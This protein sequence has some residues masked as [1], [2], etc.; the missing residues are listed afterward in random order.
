MST[1]VVVYEAP[2]SPGSTWTA[3]VPDLP[4]LVAVG[5]TLEECRHLMAA[6]LPD[7][8]AFMRERGLPVPE[9]ST[10]TEEL[11]VAA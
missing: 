8:V 4:G 10:R 2:S 5:V 1:Y 6:A 7:H 11:A 9:P 3:Y